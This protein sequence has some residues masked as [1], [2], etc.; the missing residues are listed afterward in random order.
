[1]VVMLTPLGGD[2]VK[3]YLIVS[4]RTCNRYI[5]MKHEQKHIY[6]RILGQNLVLLTS[7]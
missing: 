5:S 7:H 3:Y 1:M 6:Q 2:L 4:Y